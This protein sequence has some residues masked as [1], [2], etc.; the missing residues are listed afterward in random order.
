[1]IVVEELKK[2][3][4]GA[5]ILYRM[6]TKAQSQIRNR[7]RHTARAAPVTPSNELSALPEC[8]AIDLLADM[9]HYE[10]QAHEFDALSAIWNSGAP[11][12]SYEI[13]DDPK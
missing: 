1:M 9:S 12:A 4:F 2:T 11:M 7:E 13:L 8:S 5:E 10:Y 3:L 6:F